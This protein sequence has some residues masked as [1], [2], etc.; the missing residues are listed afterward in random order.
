MQT[1]S[2]Q[3]EN[4]DNQIWFIFISIQSCTYQVC[5]AHQKTVVSSLLNYSG[6]FNICYSKHGA[7]RMNVKTIYYINIHR[8]IILFG[9]L[10]TSENTCM[11]EQFKS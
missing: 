3:L 8:T 6:H 1:N 10:S 9:V 11:T 2:S 5:L 4:D 7:S